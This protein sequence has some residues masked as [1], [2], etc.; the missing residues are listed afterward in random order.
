MLKSSVFSTLLTKLIPVSS[1]RVKSVCCFFSLHEKKVVSQI[2]IP[3]A[4]MDLFII[5]ET[6][7]C[8]L[9]VKQKTKKAIRLRRMTFLSTACIL[10]YINSRDFEQGSGLLPMTLTVLEILTFWDRLQ[11]FPAMHS[12]IFQT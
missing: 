3:I 8:K 6:Q 5:R 7:C 9:T 4:T 1:S 2:R 12:D 11:V 10:Q